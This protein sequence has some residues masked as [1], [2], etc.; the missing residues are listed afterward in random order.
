MNLRYVI[1]K[2]ILISFKILPCTALHDLLLVKTLTGVICNIS[3]RGGGE[4][5]S[6]VENSDERAADGLETLM[7]SSPTSTSNNLPRR[8]RRRVRC[9][10]GKLHRRGASQCACQSSITPS[11]LRAPPRCK[12]LQEHEAR[13]LCSGRL[14]EAG[15]SQR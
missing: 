10:R 9:L 12:P 6:S 2:T 7:E 15:K 5:V 8:A 11:L 3:L 4:F 14:L 13:G 1:H